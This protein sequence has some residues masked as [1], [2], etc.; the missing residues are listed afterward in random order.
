[1]RGSNTGRPEVGP[2]LTHSLQ[3]LFIFIFIFIFILILI[4]ILILFPFLLFCILR[5]QKRPQLPG[6]LIPVDPAGRHVEDERL[7]WLKRQ[8]GIRKQPVCLEKQ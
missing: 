3:P 7:P 2:Y 6:R 1:M 5:L 8:L 4:L